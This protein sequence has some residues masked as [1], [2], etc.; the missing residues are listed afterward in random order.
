MFIVL[1]HY[2]TPLDEVEAHLEAH[3]RFLELHH[4]SGLFLCSGPRRPRTGGVILARAQSREALEAVLDQDPFR[5]NGVAE[6][7]LIE[8]SVTKTT[9]AVAAFAD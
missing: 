9:P 4:A 3:R 5:K 2:T 8:F 1:V 7:E 6:Y